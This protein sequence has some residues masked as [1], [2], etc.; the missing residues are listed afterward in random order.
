MLYTITMPDLIISTTQKHLDIETI[1]H[2]LV[3]LKNGSAA[4]ILQVSAVNFGLLSDEEQDATIYAY[5]GLLNS[6][7]FPI[8]IIIQ[9]VKKDISQYLELLAKQEKS[10]RNPIMQK[11]MASYRQF[12]SKIIV[13][14]GVLEKHFYIVIPYAP[15]TLNPKSKFDP[16]IIKKALTDLEPKRDHLIKQFNRIGLN[17]RQLNTK[18][19][20]KLFSSFYNPAEK[21]IK[22]A[23]PEEYQAPLVAPNIKQA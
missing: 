21:G 4:L 9:S 7:S 17:A 5:A 6:L 22:Y 10:L 23:Y 2:D 16:A 12:V 14:R 19:L 18:N 15:I 8:Q 20:I 1:S 13:E 11:R 3:F